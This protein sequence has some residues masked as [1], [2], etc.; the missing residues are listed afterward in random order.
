MHVNNSAGHETKYYNWVQYI[1][2]KRVTW[3]V[4]N[5][6]NG[7]FE[8]VVNFPRRRLGSFLVVLFARYLRIYNQTNQPTNP[9][10][11]PNSTKK[12]FG[13][14]LMCT[15]ANI[16]EWSKRW[17]DEYNNTDNPTSSLITLLFR[18]ELSLARVSTRQKWS[19]PKT[20]A[21]QHVPNHKTRVKIFILWQ[22]DDKTILCTFSQ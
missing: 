21:E 10:L 4:E 19:C 16:S 15:Y 14:L 1:R 2:A 5:S 17:R 7:S 8:P 18:V 20:Q 12:S 11:V 6:L 22:E 9:V 3:K 13:S